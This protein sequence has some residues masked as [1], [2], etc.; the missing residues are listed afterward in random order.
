MFELIVLA[1]VL[2]AVFGFMVLVYLNL[3]DSYKKS[4][5]AQDEEIKWYQDYILKLMR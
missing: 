5:E 3:I 1:A 2:V 4:I